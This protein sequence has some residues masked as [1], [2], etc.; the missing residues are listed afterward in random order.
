MDGKK[1]IITKVKEKKT[2]SFWRC[3]DGSAVDGKR[4]LESLCVFKDRAV[5]LKAV[6]C[7]N[8][9]MNA[10]ATNTCLNTATVILQ[11]QKVVISS[12]RESRE[13][14]YFHFEGNLKSLKRN[15][16]L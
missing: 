15:D 11:L 8:S 7:C 16:V 3:G 13:S 1:L 6:K 9:K 10:S 2:Y 5:T 14:S 4:M 12:E